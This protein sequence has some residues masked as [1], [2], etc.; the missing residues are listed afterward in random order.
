L[1][2]TSCVLTG[3]NDVVINELELNQEVNLTLGGFQGL[4]NVRINSVS[5]NNIYID[6]YTSEDLSKESAKELGDSV[7]RQYI[8]N[9]EPES[10]LGKEFG[11]TSYTY[12]VRVFDNGND[13]IVKGE[14]RRFND[15]IDWDCSIC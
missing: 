1:T 7:I 2:I 6:A 13:I 15:V 3:E 9:A 5:G 10:K 8:M 11:P 14:K 12:I 4:T